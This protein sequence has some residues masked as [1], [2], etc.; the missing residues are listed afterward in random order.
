MSD[1]INVLLT[2]Q[3]DIH[4][5]MARSMANLKKMG[6]ANIT[7]HA[8]K[9]RSALL[10]QLW[11]KFE[12]QHE[13]IRAHYKEAFDQ[14]EYNTVARLGNMSP[15]RRLGIK[16]CDKKWPRSWSVLWP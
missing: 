3:S 2:A 14:N 11:T 6:M 1:E 13:F 5:R 7:L 15:F 4:G 8:V 9:T 12:K 10:D 16:I